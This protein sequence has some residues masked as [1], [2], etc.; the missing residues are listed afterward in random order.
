MPGRAPPFASRSA[1]VYSF[2]AA[3]PVAF[4]CACALRVRIARP[5]SVSAFASQRERPC[6]SPLAGR[7]GHE[8]LCSVVGERIRAGRKGVAG[9]R[10][11]G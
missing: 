8:A 4:R 2:A 3:A 6:L 5:W 9:E 10:R 1:S 7:K 11:N